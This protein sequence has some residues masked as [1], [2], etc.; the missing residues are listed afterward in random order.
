MRWVF[1]LASVVAAAAAVV[2]G[3]ADGLVSTIPFVVA[4]LMALC[5]VTF[6]SLTVSI[7]AEQLHVS[8][9]PGWIKKRFSVR[10]ISAAQKVENR[11]FYGWGVKLTPHGWLFNV[12][13]F[14]AVEVELASGRRY[15]IGS[16]QPDEL[17]RA[18]QSAAAAAQAAP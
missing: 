2:A 14:D 12:S 9:G 1:G 7:D 18:I 15:R 16:D 5:F 13:G 4:A 8:F 6:Y 11:W 10:E 17:V 3:D